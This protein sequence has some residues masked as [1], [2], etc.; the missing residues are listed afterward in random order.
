MHWV[1]LTIAIVFEVMATSALKS[2]AGFTRFVPSL[3]VVVGYSVAF[4]MLSLALKHIQMGVA[5]AVWSGVGI[6]L[7]S[8]I[9]WA[10]FRQK[11]DFAAV[12]GIALIAAG[13]LVINLFSKTGLH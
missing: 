4:Y 3:I 1:Y 12:C 6:V 7:I 9:G 5:Y 13:V 11:L 2:S 10:V 8:V